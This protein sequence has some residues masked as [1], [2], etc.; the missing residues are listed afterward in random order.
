MGTV[1]SCR[2]GRCSFS[3]QT[4]VQMLISAPAYFGSLG[5]DGGLLLSFACTPGRT[6]TH[7][8]QLSRREC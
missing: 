4:V 3:M 2:R 8:A 6:T 7:S 5:R 1:W